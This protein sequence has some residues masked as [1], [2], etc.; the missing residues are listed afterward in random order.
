[1]VRVAIAYPER[2]LV[3][4]L[5][6]LLSGCHDI[7]VVAATSDVDD[8]VALAATRPPDVVVVEPQ[9]PARGRALTRLLHG[10]DPHMRVVV[11]ERREGKNARRA[12]RR[13]GADGAIPKDATADE[14]VD[15]ILR[16]AQTSPDRVYPDA[17][18]DEDEAP[19]R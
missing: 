9:T 1:M 16:V 13:A 14:V 5:V 10:I 3:D 8:I 12:A 4:G 18:F 2:L 6:S 15:E 19:P 17:R 11:V 7:R